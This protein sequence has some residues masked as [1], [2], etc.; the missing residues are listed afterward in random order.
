MIPQLQN[1]QCV[2]HA[3]TRYNTQTWTHIAR[4]HA[5]NRYASCR[6]PQRQA[7]YVEIQLRIAMQDAR[8]YHAV[9]LRHADMYAYVSLCAHAPATYTY[10]T[11]CNR[12]RAH[13]RTCASRCATRCCHVTC[14]THAAVPSRTVRRTYVIAMIASIDSLLWRAT[15]HT[16]GI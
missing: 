9:L 5:T 14:V 11:T 7:D 10:I 2:L 8:G 1:T 12:M 4:H 15:T 3:R 6:P 13:A 16:S